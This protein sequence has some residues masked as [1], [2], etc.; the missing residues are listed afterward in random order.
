[1]NQPAPPKLAAPGAGL[2]LWQ[3]I[4]LR[5]FFFPRYVKKM[6]WESSQVFFKK[7]GDN[8]LGIARALN[9][10]SLTQ[11]V[12]VKPIIGIEDSSR[13][14]SV[15]MVM[16]HLIIVGTQMADGIIE[17]THGRVPKKEANTATVKPFENRPAAVIIPKYQDF[18]ENFLK[19][20]TQGIGDRQSEQRFLHPWF[21]PLKASQW[22]A[23]AAIHQQIHHKQAVAITKG[24]S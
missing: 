22:I 3:L 4:A 17:M 2:P 5:Y 21:G 13:Y 15:S 11:Q 1:M 14:W 12:L 23:L 18:L 7:Q 6:T 8:I 19:R 24:M 20:T 9:P 10:E 16:E